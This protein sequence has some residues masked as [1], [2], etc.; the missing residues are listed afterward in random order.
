MRPCRQP[1]I[2]LHRRR[3]RRVCRRG[4]VPRVRPGPVA[5]HGR[6]A[7]PAGHQRR[8]L[9]LHRPVARRCHDNGTDGAPDR[10][11]LESPHARR[12]AGH[13]HRRRRTRATPP[14]LTELQKRVVAV[15]VGGR[16]LGRRGSRRRLDDEEPLRSGAPAFEPVHRVGVERLGRRRRRTRA[17]S[18][19]P[20]LTAADTPKLTLKWA[21]GFP[22]GNSAY[23]QPAVVG[24]RV[25]VGADTG[26]VYAL[27]AED[28]LRA[29][30]V[31]RQ[32]RRAHG[33]DGRARAPAQHRYLLYFGDIRANVYAVNAETGAQVW[34]ERLDTHPI[35][36]VTGAPTL[37][38]G[39]LYVPLS[40]LE[41]SGAGNPELS[42]L[43]VPRRR[44]RLRRAHRQAALEVLHRRRRAEAARR[45]P[46]RARSS[47]RRPAP[48]C[49]RRPRSTSSARL[50]YV[51]TGNGYTEPADDRLGR[52]DCLRH[53]H[54]Q[55]P[56]GEAGHGRAITTCATAR[57][58]TGPTCRPTTSR[59]PAPTTSGP[60]STSAT[61]RSCARCRT[62]RA[63]IVI[64]QKCGHAWG[65]DPDNEGR[66]R[67]EPPAGPGLGERRRRHDVGLGRRR[68][69]RL[70]PRDARRRPAR[71]GGASISP[72]AS[73]RGARS[74]RPAAAA[75]VTVMPGVVFLGASTGTVYAYST[76]DGKAIWQFDTARPFETVN[77]VEAT[78]GNINAAGP[79]VAGGMVFVHVG[80][81]GSR[82]RRSRQR[83]AAFG[84]PVERGARSW[85]AAEA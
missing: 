7:A 50:V 8:H 38:D 17:S 4:R 32:R 20:G 54:R 67:V 48:A 64:G 31:P 1:A 43:H 6:P 13:D 66:R 39:R 57:A 85:L 19:T 24:G 22:M 16:P 56:V 9:R 40:S 27:D 51:A 73:S 18:P 59:R 11:T 70:L 75:P 68:S 26:F 74:R 72:A 81:F 82:R 3:V 47:G 12:G 36:R 69:A 28:R 60:T 77:G 23:G 37:A 84:V 44:G 83:A 42:V 52:R 10:Y 53:R 25:F 71:P 41:E 65:L 78:G 76:P 15:Y 46:R 58:S 35:A 33:A 34:T 5:H 29:L 61:R 62:A 63:F 80:L 14:D 45:R 49:G 2:V 30:V 21:F 79:V 55:A